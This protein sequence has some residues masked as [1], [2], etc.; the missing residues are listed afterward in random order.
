MQFMKRFSTIRVLAMV[1]ILAIPAALTQVPAGPD[2]GAPQAGLTVKT[3]PPDPH[4]ETGSVFDPYAPSEAGRATGG[5]PGPS[6]GIFDISSESGA[7]AGEPVPPAGYP[8]NMAQRFSSR[9]AGPWKATGYFRPTGPDGPVMGLE[10]FG[11]D[12]SKVLFRVIGS[13]GAT[14]CEILRVSGGIWFRPN[15]FT[16]IKRCG[17]ELMRQPLLNSMFTLSDA[18]FLFDFQTELT[19]L[20]RKPFSR[21]VDGVQSFQVGMEPTA[22]NSYG[23]AKF[24]A[25]FS[26]LSGAPVML[27]FPDSKTI[28]FGGDSP[29]GADWLSGRIEARTQRK[30]GRSLTGETISVIEVTSFEVGVVLT[31]GIFKPTE[32]VEVNQ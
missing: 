26:T 13:G 3:S 11:E 15:A 10:L 6:T 29:S 17:S 25:F 21:V 1:F 7:V 23:R 16:A 14:V 31:D 8:G 9:F 32:R 5:I 27:M 22:Q 20:A 24:E 30:G 18:V 28:E 19:P 2:F 4:A 12:T